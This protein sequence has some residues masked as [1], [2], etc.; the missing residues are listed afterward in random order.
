MATEAKGR[1]WRST[2]GSDTQTMYPTQSSEPRIHTQAQ[3]TQTYTN[4]DTHKCRH[5]QMQTHTN[6]QTY[7]HADI[8]TERH[9]FTN[10]NR[11]RARTHTRAH[12]CGLDGRWAR[13]GIG[14]SASS[15]FRTMPTAT[16]AS[17]HAYIQ[18]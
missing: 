8:H 1:N 9:T 17:T 7:T 15:H 13:E 12:A 2:P 3:Q 10:A 4:V 14:A 16:H 5:T 18:D 6:T 11:Q